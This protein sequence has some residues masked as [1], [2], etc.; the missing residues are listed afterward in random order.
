MRRLVL[1]FWAAYFAA[2][3]LTNALD[4]L[5]GWGLL[6]E[7]WR[8]VSGNLPLL[9]RMLGGVGLPATLARLLLAGIVLWQG[10]T[11]WLFGQALL[12]GGGL[13]RA[14][15][16]A[17]GLWAAFL[18]GDELFLQYGLE[19]VHLKLFLAQVLSFFVVRALPDG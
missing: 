1:G 4:L 5:G 2:I 3:C 15:V 6:P 17:T 11:A 16:A 8:Y 19:S 7:G 13:E 10:T 12:Q 14:F 9:V 18:I